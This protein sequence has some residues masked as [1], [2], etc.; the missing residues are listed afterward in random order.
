MWEWQARL[1]LMKDFDS[2]NTREKSAPSDRFEEGEA[3]K[4]HQE[5]VK[6]ETGPQLILSWL[7]GACLSLWFV[8]CF[9][10]DKLGGLRY[11]HI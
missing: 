4:G 5:T 1:L 3:T 10:T 7:F 2:T 9:E 8:A 6:L 11:K